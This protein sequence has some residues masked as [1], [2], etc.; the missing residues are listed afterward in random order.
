V[1]FAS[2]LPLSVP[3]IALVDFN[4]DCVLDSLRTLKAMFEAYR[5]AIETGQ[6]EEARR[7]LL[8]GVR[9]DTGA[10]T[11]DVNIAPLGDPALDM[12]VNP[13]LVFTVRQALDDAWK[14]WDLPDEW[15]GR[16]RAY[17]HNVQIA[18]SGGF[19]P[20]KIS[21]FERLDVPVDSYGVGP[22]LMS[23]E[24]AVSAHTNF[25]S[26]VVRVKLHGQW[27]EMSKVGRQACDNPDLQVVDWSVWD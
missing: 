10:A 22:A 23:D 4:N 1:T 13:R 18:V 21:L 17:C 2:V 11:R 9:L 7:Y 8:A 24:N 20:Q 14:E 16:A 6:D 3:R 27:V 26:D 25:T 19:N 12:G 5:A 15:R